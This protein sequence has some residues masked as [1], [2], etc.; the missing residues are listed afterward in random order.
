MMSRIVL[1]PTY[2]PDIISFAHLAQQEV[3]WEV[4][5]HYQKQ[6]YRN[7]TYI[8]TDQG[9]QML[10]IP[11][12]HVGGSQGR[13]DYRSVK[14]ENS[15]PWQRQHWR[16]IQTAYRTSPFFEFYEDEL[17]PLFENQFTYLMELNLETARVLCECLQID[18][19]EHKTTRWESEPAGAVDGRRLVNAKADYIVTIPEYRQV[20]MDRHGFLQNLSTLDLL[21]N[22]GPEAPAYLD[23]LNLNTDNA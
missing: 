23:Q 1:H 8:A 19:P 15:Y 14:L 13:Q 10:N 6:T 16:G 20:F 9:R 4:Q 7:R 5:D 12:K 18:F 2:F 3:V 17:L 22:L 11:I 21:F